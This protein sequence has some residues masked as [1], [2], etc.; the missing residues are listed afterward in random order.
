MLENVSAE[1]SVCLCVERNG[2]EMGKQK[3]QEV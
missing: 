2:L 3:R 1:A